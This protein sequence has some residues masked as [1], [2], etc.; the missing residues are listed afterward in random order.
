MDNFGVSQPTTPMSKFEGT[1][2]IKFDIDLK[3]IG[4]GTYQG[5]QAQ[6]IDEVLI[7]NFKNINRLIGKDIQMCSKIIK[8]LEKR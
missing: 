1:P 7:D 6:T 3:T 8:D 2:L 5:L 4:T